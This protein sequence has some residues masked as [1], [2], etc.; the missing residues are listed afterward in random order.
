MSM[1]RGFIGNDGIFLTLSLR[2]SELA[3]ALATLYLVRQFFAIYTVSLLS[4]ALSGAI[5]SDAGSSFKIAR[6]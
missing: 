3:Y 1:V 5:L 4:A 2:R 6:V